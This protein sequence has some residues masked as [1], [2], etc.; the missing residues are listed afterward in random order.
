MLAEIITIGDELL[1][2]LTVDTNSA[3]MGQFLTSF[4]FKIHQ[5][6]TISDKREDILAAINNSINRADLVLVTGG[7]GPTSDDITKETIAEYFDS[8]LIKNEFVYSY[9]EEILNLRG[10]EMNDNNRRQAM[11]PDICTVLPN[12]KGTAPGMLF[13]KEGSVLISM[14]GVPYEMKDIMENHV[15]PYIKNNFNNKKRYGRRFY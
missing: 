6:T 4:G 10:L 11:V 3:W 5:Q 13:E 2:G 8:K 15:T 14:P 9:I 1:M 7:L 12:G